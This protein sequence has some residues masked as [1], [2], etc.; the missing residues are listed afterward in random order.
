MAR[1]GP[2]WSAPDYQ[3]SGAQVDVADVADRL[4]GF[5]R[6]DTRGRVVYLDTFADGLG[7]YFLNGIGGGSLPSAI[8]EQGRG[9]AGPISAYMVPGNTP[10]GRSL[11]VRNFHLGSAKRIGVEFAFSLNCAVADF[12]VTLAYTRKNDTAY[13][14]VFRVNY[15]SA[16]IEIQVGAVYTPIATLDLSGVGGSFIIVKVV[17]DFE[18]HKYVRLMLGDVQYDI[19]AYGLSTSGQINDG[20]AIL[21]I[22]PFRISGAGGADYLHYLI[23]TKDEQ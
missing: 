2:D 19:D 13:S 23:I 11:M 20:M 16:A 8:V 18:T 15:A 22:F 21:N 6:V 14:V 12:Y 9:F 7:G 4:L 10:D 3:L 5:A 1:G 17:G